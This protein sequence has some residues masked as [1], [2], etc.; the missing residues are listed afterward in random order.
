MR[1]ITAVLVLLMC[2]SVVPA[3]HLFNQGPFGEAAPADELPATHPLAKR[4]AALRYFSIEYEEEHQ[5]LF[6]HPKGEPPKAELTEKLQAF[7]V[8]IE[9]HIREYE[10]LADQ[11][12]LSGAP[13]YAALARKFG[14]YWRQRLPVMRDEVAFQNNERRIEE[15]IRGEGPGADEKRQKAA[16]AR[17]REIRVRIAQ[18]AFVAALALFIV[19]LALERRKKKKKA[20]DAKKPPG[21]SS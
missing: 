20:K 16:E 9:G 4:F 5:K 3:Q 8:K 11:L 15:E 14:G 17:E 13:K 1:Y 19:V 6:F 12:T 10:A 18:F 2:A 21:P 7:I